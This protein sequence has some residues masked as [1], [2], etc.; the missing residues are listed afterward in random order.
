MR[1]ALTGYGLYRPDGRITG[2]EIAKESGIPEDVVR[3]K[4]GIYEKRICPPEDDHVTDM[5]VK[6]GQEALEDADV[7]PEAV[8]L[9]L[10]HGS[11]YKDYVVW[12][13]AAQIADRLGT[14]NA[15]ASENHTLCA[16]TPVAIRQTRAQLAAGDIDVALHVTAS[17]EEDLVD[18]TD[19]DASFM[20]NFGSGGGAYVLE[21]GDDEKRSLA[22]I[23]ESAAISDGSFAEDVV[24]PAGGSR[25]P[26]SAETIEA[27][28]H[29]LTVRDPDEMKERMA[30][31]S[32]PN[33]QAVA[34]EALERSG[35][36]RVDVDFVA[37]THMKRSFAESIAD[38]FGLDLASGSYYLEE[39]G[40]VQSV[41]QI[42]A[43]DEG[44]QCDRVEPGDLVL[45]LAA[46]TGYTWSATVLEWHG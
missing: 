12:S 27:G 2:E 9:V 13:A 38:E 3:E 40:H 24:M 37:L 30:P 17:R 1:V 5:C 4:M 28:E 21:R 43:L 19:Q 25:N 39:Y 42:L 26:T 7:E 36:E 20:F 46:G 33:F 23:H 34:D 15:Y 29:T 18:Y 35:F 45:F 41:D 22:T 32:G 6:A 11:E 44:R 14:E 10:Y 8:D 31:V 16:S